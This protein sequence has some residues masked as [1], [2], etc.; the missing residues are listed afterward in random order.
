MSGKVRSHW[1]ILI[2]PS[3]FSPTSTSAFRSVSWHAV[4]FEKICERWLM[5]S[6]ARSIEVFFL[7][8]A[9]DHMLDL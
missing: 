9:L 7:G 8:Q 1:D 5:W 6:N 3:S 2:M 4:S